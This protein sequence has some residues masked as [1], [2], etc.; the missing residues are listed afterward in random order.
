MVP[1]IIKNKAKTLMLL[2]F[3]INNEGFLSDSTT[4]DRTRGTSWWLHLVGGILASGGTTGQTWDSCHSYTDLDKHME[5]IP[6]RLYPFG[7]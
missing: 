7:Q 3:F 4:G 1:I 2:F 6:I 5:W